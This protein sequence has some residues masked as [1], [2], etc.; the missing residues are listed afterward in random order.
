MIVQLLHGCRQLVP[1]GVCLSAETSATPTQ[2][3]IVFG[4]CLAYS[5]EEGGDDVKSVRSL[6]LGPHTSYNGKEQWVAKPQGG[7]NPNK[8][9][10]SS[11]W[12]L[13]L[14]PMKTD[15]VV[16][17]D[18]QGRGEYVLTLCTHRPSSQQSWGR[19]KSRF[20]QDK[21]EFSDEG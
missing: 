10:L 8:T 3:S 11:D 6:Y 21:G 15:L 13:Q 16:I 2:C 20:Y 17:A 14:A 19:L 4:N 18:Q 1:W 5:G 12:G 7:A 9:S